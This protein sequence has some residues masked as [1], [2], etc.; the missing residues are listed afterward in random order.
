MLHRLWAAGDRISD[1]YQV[2]EHLAPDLVLK[3]LSDCG[4]PFLV[5]TCGGVECLN[6]ISEAYAKLGDELCDHVADL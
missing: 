5:A 3:A 6:E 4:V 1:L 2:G